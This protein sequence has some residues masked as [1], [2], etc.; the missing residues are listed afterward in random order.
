MDLAMRV[1]P[2]RK[3]GEERKEI[4]TL[5]Y[6]LSILSSISLPENRAQLGIKLYI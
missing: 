3:K 5:Q 2:K 6:P 1:L 4:K